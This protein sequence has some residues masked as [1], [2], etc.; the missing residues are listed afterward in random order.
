MGINGDH[1]YT[2]YIN[3]VSIGELYQIS[4]AQQ[5]FNNQSTDDNNEVDSTPTIDINASCFYC[6]SSII[7]YNRFSWML[8][9]GLEL[10]Q[11]YFLLM[12]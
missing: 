11:I 7:T 1:A 6:S 4:L 2:H 8:D 5:K 12:L 9:L 10:A 3:K